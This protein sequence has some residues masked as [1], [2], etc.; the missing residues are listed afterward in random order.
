MIL[1]NF[2]LSF[3]F[4]RLHLRHMEV[5]CGRIRAASATYTTAQSNIRSLT[6]RVRPGM[7][8]SP[9]GI[10]VGFIN[11]WA[12]TG[13]PILWTI[14]EVHSVYRIIQGTTLYPPSDWRNK[15]VPIHWGS[16]GISSRLHS[17]WTPHESINT[18]VKSDR[19][20]TVLCFT[21]LLHRSASLHR[22]EY[23][24]HVLFIF[25]IN[26]PQHMYSSV[27]L[28]LSN[29]TFLRFLHVNI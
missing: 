27:T 22:I 2:F 7:E 13:T 26:E 21:Q 3:V 25:F 10:L 8:P 9:S 1:W 12:T 4:L 16:Q 11:H 15:T 5:P 19:I 17:Y 29:I 24:V 18:T 23:P 20:I 28:S 6:H 14:E